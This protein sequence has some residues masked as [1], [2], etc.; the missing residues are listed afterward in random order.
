MRIKL[1]NRYSV[2]MYGALTDVLDFITRVDNQVVDVVL[3]FRHPLLTKV[4]TSVTGLGSGTAALVFLGV[5][6]LAG[7]DE[8]LYTSA[9]ALAITG[10][11]VATLWATIQRP[12]PPG[13]VCMTGDTSS[14]AASFPSGH[15]GAVTIYAMAARKSSV[16]PF[17]V[18]ALLAGTIA[19]S[20]VYLGTHYFSDTVAGVLIG[21][22]AFYGATRLRQHALVTQV[23]DRL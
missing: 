19:I 23:T 3:A 7:W 17:G 2:D 18:V 15:A 22:V 20:R 5:C 21:V 16:L 4:M 10:I 1:H 11:C 14:V 9:I 6:Y 13:P 12:L 8:E